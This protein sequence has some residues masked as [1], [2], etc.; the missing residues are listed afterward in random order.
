MDL[1]A[2][3]ELMKVSFCAQDGLSPFPNAGRAFAVPVPISRTSNF[4]VFCTDPDQFWGLICAIFKEIKDVGDRIGISLSLW[5][6]INCCIR[7]MGVWTVQGTIDSPSLK[8]EVCRAGTGGG[9]PRT[10]AASR[11]E[12]GIQSEK[13]LTF[14]YS[15]SKWQL[16]IQQQKKVLASPASYLK[17]LEINC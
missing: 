10:K 11:S 8:E 14:N 17:K 2:S 15:V 7:G 6:L 9:R 1:N 16:Q 5:Q 3:C 4:H 12:F 13:V